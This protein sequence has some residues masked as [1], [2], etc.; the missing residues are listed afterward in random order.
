MVMVNFFISVIHGG[1]GKQPW[2]TA[3]TGATV[4]NRR[5]G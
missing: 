5:D 1:K 4:P 2:A 3:A